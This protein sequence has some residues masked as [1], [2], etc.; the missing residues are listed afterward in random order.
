[1]LKAILITIVVVGVL[2]GGLLT[3]RS[4]ARTG[5]PDEEVLKRA[6]GR[7]REQEAKDEADKDR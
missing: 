6:A 5:M 4:S 7:A 2:I 3:L 1:M